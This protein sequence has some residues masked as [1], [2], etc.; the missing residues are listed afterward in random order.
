MQKFVRAMV[1]TA[2]WI[3]D[4]ILSIVYA[5]IAGFLYFIGICLFVG[6]FYYPPY[7]SAFM[8]IGGIITVYLSDCM[9]QSSPP[10]F[11][12]LSYRRYIARLGQ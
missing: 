1:M 5:L 11:L 7:Y 2:L 10:W 12:V 8:V 3:G 6:S 9:L 4:I